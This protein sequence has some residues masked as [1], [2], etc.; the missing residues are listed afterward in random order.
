MSPEERSA[1]RAF[2]PE[3]PLD[4]DLRNTIVACANALFAKKGIPVTARKAGVFAVDF[5]V[6]GADKSACVQ[7]ALRQLL[8]DDPGFRTHLEQ[9]TVCHTVEIWG[10]KFS[11]VD[12]G[13]DYLICKAF[14]STVRAMDFRQEDLAELDPTYNIR[15][16]DGA[17]SLCDAVIEYFR[18]SHLL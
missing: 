11:T 18:R 2:L 1:F 5:A 13:T 7:L 9:D 4:A 17:E 14:P 8:Q 3:V 6:D 16:W 12:G 10:D 15:L